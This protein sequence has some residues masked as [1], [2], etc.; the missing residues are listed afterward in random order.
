[1]GDKSPKSK[2]KE[3]KQNNAVKEKKSSDMK[4]KQAPKTSK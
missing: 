2:D 3:K 4:A 1:V